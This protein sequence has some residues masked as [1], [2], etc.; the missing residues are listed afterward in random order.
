MCPIHPPK[1]PGPCCKASLQG[2]QAEQVHLPLDQVACCLGRQICFPDLSSGCFSSDAGVPELL[3]PLVCLRPFLCLFCPQLPTA[4]GVAPCSLGV[5]AESS[6]SLATLDATCAAACVGRW[7]SD[8]CQCQLPEPAIPEDSSRETC[9]LGR[10]VQPSSLDHTLPS[11]EM[12]LVCPK[13]L[14]F[15]CHP[16]GN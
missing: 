14:N 11:T 8:H 9:G 6:S 16:S 10:H 1:V 7:C 5:P 4:R 12:N 15:K 13:A 3:R 2:W